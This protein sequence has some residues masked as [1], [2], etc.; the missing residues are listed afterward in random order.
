MRQ[1]SEDTSHADAERTGRVGG[2]MVT[3]TA[4]ACGQLLRRRS[5][6]GGITELVVVE[7]EDA[8]LS[9]R[10]ARS[11]S[12][13]ADVSELRRLAGSCRCWS[14]CRSAAAARAA[15]SMAAESMTGALRL[16]GSPGGEARGTACPLS[17]LDGVGP[18]QR[19]PHSEQLDSGG[20]VDGATEPAA[21]GKGGGSLDKGSG[22]CAMKR[23]SRSR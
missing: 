9:A 8:L 5:D 4:C 3:V 10:S 1:R 12:P 6:R 13:A 16:T 17:V 7:D 14:R 2:E 20:G 19:T 15:A 23:K 11:I 21:Q 22:K 18:T